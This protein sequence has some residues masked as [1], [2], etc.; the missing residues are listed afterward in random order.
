MGSSTGFAMVPETIP[1]KQ[2]FMLVIMPPGKWAKN[3]DFVGTPLLVHPS[4][5]VIIAA[6]EQKANAWSQAGVIAT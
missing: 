6:G 4:C 1:L 2:V 5:A 3:P